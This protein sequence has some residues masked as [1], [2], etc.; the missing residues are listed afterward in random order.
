MRARL[1]LS[2]SASA[3]FSTGPVKEDREREREREVV[4]AEKEPL[5]TCMHKNWSA[6]LQAVPLG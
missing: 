6:M 4:A 1:A 2:C 3:V 5:H